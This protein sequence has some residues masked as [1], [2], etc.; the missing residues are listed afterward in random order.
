MAA[1]STTVNAGPIFSDTSSHIA[2][3]TLAIARLPDLFRPANTRHGVRSVAFHPARP[4]AAVL[5]VSGVA[6]VIAIAGRTNRVQYSFPFSS[7]KRARC[8]CWASGGERFLTGG[9]DDVFQR[10][11]CP[12]QS[13]RVCRLPDESETITS[14]CECPAAPLLAMVAGPRVHFLDAETLQTV[15]TVATSD[16]LECGCCLVVAIVLRFDWGVSIYY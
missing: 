3:R 9:D 16:A 6:H 1:P 4:E 13:V 8:I 7:R 12:S 14:I 5:D 10:V 2:P 11:D 15:Q